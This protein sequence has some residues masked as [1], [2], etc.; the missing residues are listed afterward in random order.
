MHTAYLSAEH[1]YFPAL[2]IRCSAPPQATH[3]VSATRRYDFIFVAAWESLDLPV[4]VCAPCKRYR[5]LIG[6]ATFIAV[7]LFI[8][9]GGFLAF[10]LLD[11][12]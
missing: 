10:V 9:A 1:L 4:P 8:F 3:D 5:R 6:A 7:L 12:E 11:S 2:C